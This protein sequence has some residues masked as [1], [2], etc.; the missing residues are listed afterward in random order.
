M[1][2]GYY[3]NGGIFVW[4]A[5][6]FLK[7]VEKHAAA[8]L[9]KNGAGSSNGDIS[10]YFDEV[11]SISIDYAVMEKSNNVAVIP[12]DVGWSDIGTWESLRRL[13]S[14]GEVKI[15]R[16]VVEAMQRA[17]G[18]VNSAE[19]DTVLVGKAFEQ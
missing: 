19:L 9:P 12:T 14:G 4:K 18:F 7:E 17:L 2:E 1:K 11:P 3:W 8:L 6:T 13:S 15:N 16:S 5:N 10:T